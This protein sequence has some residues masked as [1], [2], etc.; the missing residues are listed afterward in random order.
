MK[1]SNAYAQKIDSELYTLMPKT[2]IAAIFVDICVNLW[3][4]SEED[5]NS[6]IAYQWRQLEAAGIV[7]QKLPKKYVALADQYESDQDGTPDDNEPS[8]AQK[9]EWA[10]DAR[11]Y[12]GGK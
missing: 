5:I 2:V 12:M 11:M 3:E 4:M 7:P 10:A 1:D 8:L 9:I 6:R